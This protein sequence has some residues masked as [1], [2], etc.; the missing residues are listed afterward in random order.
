MKEKKPTLKQWKA[1]YELAGVIKKGRPWDYLYDMDIVTLVIPEEEEPVFCS[2]MGMNG[3]CFGISLLFGYEALSGL[4]RMVES[5]GDFNASAA[6]LNCINLYF[7]DRDELY[8]EDYETIRTLGLRF[9]GKNQWPFFRSHMPGYF[10]WHLNGKEALRTAR[11]LSRLAEAIEAMKDQKLKVDFEGGET[12][13]YRPAPEGKAWQAEAV[14]MP[15]IPINSISYVMS[16]ELM[17]G[18]L[19]K[20][21]KKK[22]VLE[23]AAPYLAIPFQDSPEERPKLA[24]MIFFVDHDTLLI[25]DS[26]LTA[27][28]RPYGEILLD[29]LINYIQEAGR[30]KRILVRDDSMEGILGDLCNKLDIELKRDPH[31]EGVSQAEADLLEHLSNFPV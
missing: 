3:Q 22:R 9:R 4:Y 6:H 12:L 11:A 17:L 28:E 26:H 20:R 5:S 2:I 30:P 31:L 18:R 27:G 13:A 21:P 10:P 25:E 1:L 19:K 23:V 8:P 7:G 14:A 29:M 15:L 24:Q 16:D